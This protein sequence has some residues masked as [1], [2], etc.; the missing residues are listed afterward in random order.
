MFLDGAANQDEI[1][2]VPDPSLDPDEVDDISSMASD[3]PKFRAK[4]HNKKR[5][6]TM[7]ASSSSMASGLSGTDSDS[8][9]EIAAMSDNDDEVRE[10]LRR[11]SVLRQNKMDMSTQTEGNQIVKVCQ[12]AEIGLQ[13]DLIS[14]DTAASKSQVKKAMQEKER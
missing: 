14:A 8:S 9:S 7:S 13:A 1:E 3:F 11:H 12:V 10:I 6:R 5:K 2:Q 4:G